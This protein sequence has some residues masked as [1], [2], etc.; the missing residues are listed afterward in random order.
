MTTKW[1]NLKHTDGYLNVVVWQISSITAL[2]HMRGMDSYCT[3]LQ[4][5]M[6]LVA[7]AWKIVD[8][9]DEGDAYFDNECVWKGYKKV[10]R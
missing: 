4:G 10:I 6:S 7:G 2:S 9:T 3:E 5:L 8:A 1:A